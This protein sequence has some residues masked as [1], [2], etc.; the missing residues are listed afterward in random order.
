MHGVNKRGLEPGWP[1]HGLRVKR[2]IVAGRR[3]GPSTPVPSWK[4]FNNQLYDGIA[5]AA[6]AHAAAGRPTPVSA[7]KLAAS[8]WE[9]QDHPLPACLCSQHWLKGISDMSSPRSQADS[10]FSPRSCKFAYQQYVKAGSENGRRRGSFSKHLAAAHSHVHHGEKGDGPDHPASASMQ[11]EGQRRHQ[12]SPASSAPS[13]HKKSDGKLGADL[14]SLTTSSELLKVLSRIRILEEQHN[15]SLTLTTTLRTELEQARAR[16][17]ELEQTQKSGRREMDIFVKK[18]N[19]EK[20]NWK[21]KEQE[22]MAASVQAVK[23]ELEEERKV[24]RRLELSN[25]K[26]NKELVEANMAAAKALQDLESERK[27]RQLMEDVCDELAREIGDDKQ[28]REEIKRESERV[29]DELEEE[30]RMLQLAEVWREERVQMKLSDAKVALEEKNAALDVMRAELEAFLRGERR[31]NDAAAVQ[32]AEVLRNVITA[33]HPRGMVASFPPIALNQAASPDNDLYTMD[34]SNDDEAQE[35]QYWGNPLDSQDV[36]SRW[37]DSEYDMVEENV[38]GSRQ[39]IHEHVHSDS[40]ELESGS[41]F[42]SESHDSEEDDDPH[43]TDRD[44]SSHWE[45]HHDDADHYHGNGNNVTHASDPQDSVDEYAHT[46]EDIVALNRP[47]GHHIE[48]GTW[49]EETYVEEDLDSHHSSRRLSNGNA[50]HLLSD[51]SPQQRTQQQSPD[52]AN[53]THIIR[54]MKGHMEWPKSN[55]DVV[56]RSKLFESN[57]ERQQLIRHR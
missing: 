52:K 55:I 22:M 4:V 26:M 46:D 16:V 48:K 29:R 19:D 28:Q 17:Q 35:G 21:A 43:E 3:G 14:S 5:A 7:R 31:D 20:A 18:I 27:A 44:E 12:H 56:M 33:M 25:R 37:E 39:N 57:V 1:S 45:G 42:V 40:K 54:G 13:N 32:E 23:D 15:A 24:R 11:C 38:H 6:A 49:R 10:Y 8:L 41:D 53:N 2:A 36:G 47:N 50:T 51:S 30:R 9:L 34:M